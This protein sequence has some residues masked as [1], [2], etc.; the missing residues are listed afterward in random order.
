MR[1]SDGPVEVENPE[2]QVVGLHLFRLFCSDCFNKWGGPFMKQNFKKCKLSYLLGAALLVGG[3]IMT[4]TAP[5]T[6]KSQ[7]TAPDNSKMNKGDAHEGANTADQ[8]KM[9]ATDRE[10][11]KKIRASIMKDKSLS[12][13]AHN[14]KI[15]TEDG[16]VTLK[17]PVRSEK[18]KSDVEAKAA[19]VAGDGNVTSEIEVAPPKS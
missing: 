6:A 12:M 16:K 19:A 7:Q 10:L 8:Q 18:E 5:L 3:V 13:Y 2:R 14:I 11:T 1:I 4:S 9:N 15:I 17:G